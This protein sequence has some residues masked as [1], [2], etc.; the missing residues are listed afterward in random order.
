[1]IRPFSRPIALVTGATSGMGLELAQQLAQHGHDLI[2]VAPD[3]APLA[4]VADHLRGAHREIQ[5]TCVMADLTAT[6]GVE[7][8]YKALSE[9]GRALDVLVANP[10]E[11]R[12]GDGST[13]TR[14]Q[15]ALA[16]INRNVTAPVH[17]VQRLIGR[18]VV[19]GT[20]KVLI[21]SSIA[22]SRLG[23]HHPVCAATRAFLRSFG[24]ALR[25]E[26]QEAGITVTVLIPGPI[27][28]LQF[29]QSAYAALEDEDRVIPALLSPL[30]APGATPSKPE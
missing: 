25:N 13:E 19:H 16:L 18:M 17:F 3:A 2:L 26:L 4:R 5:V 23:P 9:M 11:D 29:A 1:M 10:G 21:T 12:Q 30:Q 22:S 28:A 15:A 14:L 8:I 6:D 24:Q 7:T 20:G 27:D